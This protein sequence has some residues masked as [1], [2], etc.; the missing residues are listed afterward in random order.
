MLQGALDNSRSWWP[1]LALSQS[2][3]GTETYHD[4]K[5]AADVF[6]ALALLI[7]LAP[8]LALIA[9]LI[10]LDSPGPIFFVQERIGA[11][12]R[13]FPGGE[14]QWILQIFP[15]YK[16]RTMHHN[17]D[18]KLHRAYM[19]AYIAGDEGA[20]ASLDPGLKS[21]TSYKLSGD[22][23]VTGL[24]HF[25]RRTS[26][27]ELPQLWNVL[28]G[29]M[30]LVGPRPPIPY[31]VEMYSQQQLHRLSTVPGITG[32][33]QVSGRCETTFDEMVRLD[34][35]Y[36]ECKSILLDFKILLLTLPAVLSVR[37]AG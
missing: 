35:E 1:Y 20:I 19:K 4:I 37:G 24:G 5:R 36:I 17:A 22:P 3:A 23:R 21:S 18:A 29:D 9:L 8:L 34:L 13:N 33:W 27:D 6:M 32:L 16:F 25:L 15:L 12:R 14:S 30:S 28:M 31:E 7:L 10:R 2:D 11:R 26:L